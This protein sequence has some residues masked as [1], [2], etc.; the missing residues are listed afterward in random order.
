M[1][2]INE[3]C[4]C[5]ICFNL[6]DDQ[7]YQ[8]E[9]GH[10]CC[11]ICINNINHCGTCRTNNYKIRNLLLE[12]LRDEYLKSNQNTDNKNENINLDK[13]DKNKK[14][15]DDKNIINLNDSVL[16]DL[17]NYDFNDEIYDNLKNLNIKEKKINT[18]DDLKKLIMKNYNNKNLYSNLMNNLNKIEKISC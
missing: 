6:I 7:I 11:K 18:D 15:K 14:D 4:S 12:K 9:N 10:L 8:C 16:Y 17:N 3:L 1:S 2:N 13:D 5:S